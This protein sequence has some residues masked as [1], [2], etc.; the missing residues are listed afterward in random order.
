MNQDTKLVRVIAEAI[1]QDRGWGNTPKDH[2]E[3]DADNPD[4]QYSMILEDARAAAKG[5][6]EY[7]MGWK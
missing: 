4:S 6:I 5:V 7:M 1:M 3:W 2:I